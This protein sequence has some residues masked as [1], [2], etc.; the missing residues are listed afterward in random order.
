MNR[1]DKPVQYDYSFDR[2]MPQFTLPNFQ[3]L[4]GALEGQEQKQAQFEELA[5]KLPQY[6]QSG[7]IEDIDPITGQKVSFSYG[8][9][10]SYNLLAEKNKQLQAEMEAAFQTGDMAIINQVRNKVMREV[11]KIHG[12]TGWATG[13]QKR[14]DDHIKYLESIQKRADEDPDWGAVN[15]NFATRQYLANIG[16]HDPA[17]QN[18]R[19]VNAPLMYAYTNIEKEIQ[20][21]AAKTG[22]QKVKIERKPDD[23]GWQIT[24]G[25][26]EATPEAIASIEAFINNPRLNE[27]YKVE[28]Y[29]MFNAAGGLDKIN[30]GMA[31]YNQGL[32]LRTQLMNKAKDLLAKPNKT[33]DEEEQLTEA[34][35]MLGFAKPEMKDG[36]RVINTVQAEQTLR[37]APDD[38]F[39]LKKINDPVGFAQKQLENRYM[40]S[41]KGALDVGYEYTLTRD[42]YWVAYQKRG[43]DIELEDYKQSF[44]N[45]PQFGS[46][47]SGDVN[48]DPIETVNSLQQA[49][50]NLDGLQQGYQTNLGSY[51]MNSK[52]SP[53]EQAKDI[54]KNGSMIMQKAG[55]IASIFKLGMTVAQLGQEL[56]KIGIPEENVRNGNIQKLHDDLTSNDF[57]RQYQGLQNAQVEANNKRAEAEQIVFDND[58]LFKDRNSLSYVSPFDPKNQSYITKTEAPSRE[59]RSKTTTYTYNNALQYSVN[60]NNYVISKGEADWLFSK[61]Y[62]ELTPYQKQ[63]RDAITVT[64]AKTPE[65]QKVPAQKSLVTVFNKGK[66]ADVLTLLQTHLNVERDILSQIAQQEVY[67]KQN[68]NILDPRDIKVT[69]G[70]LGIGDNGLPVV[71]LKLSRAK[72]GGEALQQG[73]AVKIPLSSLTTEEFGDKAIKNAF[74]D[75]ATTNIGE[76]K[77]TETDKY[78]AGQIA[79]YYETGSSLTLQNAAVQTMKREKNNTEKPIKQFSATKDNQKFSWIIYGIKDGQG[80][81]SFDV[82]KI[83]DNKPVSVKNGKFQNIQDAQSWV[84]YLLT[85]PSWI[86]TVRIKPETDT[87]KVKIND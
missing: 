24:E 52:L 68:V 74:F 17:A 75:D 25:R 58:G 69:V 48:T 37:D 64:I 85:Q 19:N 60:G 28:R 22:D 77:A 1:F 76:W 84:G 2:Y 27:Q 8:D 32:D 16:K 50:Q 53:I 7:T 83:E 39:E 15:K 54:L 40:L 41:G 21:F 38:Y 4:A 14:Y 56:I 12:P 63:H 51:F 42:P 6:I 18:F 87:R 29:N 26:E 66:T 9:T 30:A 34:Y 20:D 13:L 67:T 35:L 44:T 23:S 73:A 45:Q 65:A 43:W 80:R 46:F 70:G 79:F 72:E 10:E 36:V 31:D 61:P 11:Q 47:L 86:E 33:K 71:E 49:Q 82:R 57:Q 3:L 62:N 55:Q 59:G 78:N 5:N 81:I